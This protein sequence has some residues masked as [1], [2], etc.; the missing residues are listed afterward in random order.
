MLILKEKLSVIVPVYNSCHYIN[1]LVESILAQTYKNIELIL[2]DDGSTDGSNILCDNWAKQDIRIKVIHKANGGQS[3]ARNKGM[4]IA[5]GDIIAFADND[6]ILHPQM[7][8]IMIQELERYDCPVCACNFKNVLQAEIEDIS[9][10]P[11]AEASWIGERELIEDFFK[12]TWRVPIWNKIY[13]RSILKNV[14][15]HDVHLG[16]DNRFSYNVIKRCKGMPFVETTMYFQRMHGANFEFTGGAFLNE[17]LLTKEE[18]LEDIKH[19]YPY[20][21]TNAHKLFVY[22]CIRIYNQFVEGNMKIQKEEAMSILL[23]NISADLFKSIPNGHKILMAL[24]KLSRGKCIR[25]KISV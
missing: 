17:L 12:P 24:L 11:P 7:Y 25:S 21:Y 22:E 8:E 19:N 4:E 23:R 3:S 13:R 20:E 16:E 10:D 6:D 9:F 2:V 18:I 15:F 1:S 5:K 14:R